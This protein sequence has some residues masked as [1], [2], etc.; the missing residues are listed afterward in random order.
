MQ[1]RFR[2]ILLWKPPTMLNMDHPGIHSREGPV[3]LSDSPFRRF[4]PNP[5][6]FLNFKLFCC[7]R[8]YLYN[9]IGVHFSEGLDLTMFRVIIGLE[10]ATCYEDQ[11]VFLS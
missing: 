11:G 3:F 6:P 1:R 4:Y 7:I 5:V 2:T 8:M 10:P 9:G